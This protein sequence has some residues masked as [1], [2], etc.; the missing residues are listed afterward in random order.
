MPLPASVLGR[1]SFSRTFGFSCCAGFGSA[2]GKE[3]SSSSRSATQCF[4]R[5]RI[6]TPAAIA[7][8]KCQTPVVEDEACR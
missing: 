1:L 5:A 8:P 7:E 4:T 3:E 2:L 6:R